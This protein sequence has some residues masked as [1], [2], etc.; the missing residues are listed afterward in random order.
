MQNFWELAILLSSVYGF[1]LYC[2]VF[3]IFFIYSLMAIVGV[4]PNILS[5]L[6]TTEPEVS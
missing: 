3:C 6:N 1:S 2:D 5:I 4:E